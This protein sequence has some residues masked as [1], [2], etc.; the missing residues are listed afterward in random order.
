MLLRH[1]EHPTK[2]ISKAN[3]TMICLRLCE[4]EL[5][6]CPGS[7]NWG[8]DTRIPH[9]I[10]TRLEY[11]LKHPSTGTASDKIRHRTQAR[12]RDLLQTLSDT[13]AATHVARSPARLVSELHPPIKGLLYGLCHAATGKLPTD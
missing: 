5:A 3:P 10:Y 13:I 11:N 12:S 9:H 7:Q 4:N 2:T 1:A 8:V 6:K